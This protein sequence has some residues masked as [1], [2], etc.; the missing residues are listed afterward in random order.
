MQ[1]HRGRYCVFDSAGRAE[2]EGIGWVKCVWGQ[3]VWGRRIVMAEGPARYGLGGDGLVK[4]MSGGELQAVVCR[5]LPVY[6][7]RDHCRVFLIAEC[8]NVIEFHA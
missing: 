3:F 4:R 7:C 6:Q 2:E 1:C 8:N 5:D